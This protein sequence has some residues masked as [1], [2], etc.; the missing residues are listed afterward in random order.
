MKN[1]NKSQKAA[2]AVFIELNDAVLVRADETG[3]WLTMSSVCMSVRS[4]MMLQALSLDIRIY[5]KNEKII[6]VLV[7]V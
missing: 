5:P 1:L 3:Y 6:T 4:V 2:I 7:T